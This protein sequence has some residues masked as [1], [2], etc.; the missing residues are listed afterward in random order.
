MAL[1]TLQEVKDYLKLP[2]GT[3]EDSM[4][5]HFILAAQAE[6][7]TRH[8]RKLEYRTVTE[9]FN[10]GCDRLFLSTY[11]VYSIASIKIDG[12]TMDASSYEWNPRTGVVLGYF[13]L[14]SVQVEYTGGYWTSTDPVPAGVQTLPSDLKHECLE[15][16]A[17]FYMHRGDQRA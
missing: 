6:L 12:V 5:N 14:G 2:T 3:A 16:V 13:G 9:T 7:E 10:G 11:P 15:Y 8:N 17:S 4:L 1:V